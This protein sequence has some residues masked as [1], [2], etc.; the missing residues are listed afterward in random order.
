MAELPPISLRTARR[1]AIRRQLLDTQ[2]PSTIAGADKA[3]IRRVFDA[4]RCIQIDPIRAVERTELLVLWSR[5]GLFDPAD[6]RT[7]VFEDKALFEDWAHCA[8]IVRMEDWPL[9]R[10]LK[11]DYVEQEARGA[12]R[13]QR[14][15][16]GNAGLLDHVRG[17]LARR[18]PLPTGDIDADVPHEPWTSSG[19]TSGRSVTRILD[20]LFARGEV[21]VADRRGNRKCWQLTSDFLPAW[22]DQRPMDPLEVSRIGLQGA[23]RALG[24]A[25][26]VHI[27]HHFM[28]GLYPQMPRVMR[29]LVEAERFLPVTVLD[30][31]DQSLPGTWYVHAS[32]LPVLEQLRDGDAPGR[33]VLLSPFDNLICNRQRTRLLFDFDYK[34][35]IYVP[36]AKRIYG[37]YVL[38]ILAG[39]RFL[40]RVDLH[41]DRDRASLNVQA[42]YLEPDRKGDLHQAADLAASLRSLATFLQARRVSLGRR[43]PVAWRR[44]LKTF[45]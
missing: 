42:L 22:A 13:L 5:I 44:A 39:D 21:M 2:G 14:W 24:V 4:L 41:M 7:L 32:D 15:A 37:Y 38:P 36:V 19:W 18:G 23:L 31:A 45:L 34:I 11:L 27:R 33:T 35:E 40:G 29:E 3:A 43:M 8:S 30:A 28:R 26:D 17:Q 1:L 10:R 12:S 25:T 6:L 9:F 16:Q 20:Y